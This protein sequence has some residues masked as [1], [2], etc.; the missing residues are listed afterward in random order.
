M[1][2]DERRWEILPGGL[3][4]KPGRLEQHRSYLFAD[5]WGLGLSEGAY[6]LKSF[7]VFEGKT[8]CSLCHVGISNPKQLLRK[9]PACQQLNACAERRRAKFKSLSHSEPKISFQKREREEEEG[10]GGISGGRE[11]ETETHQIHGQEEEER[12]LNGRALLP[13]PPH[14]HHHQAPGYTGQVTW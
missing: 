13:P 2:R 11:R 9:E 4:E 7:Q 8:D 12:K 14:H 10:G 3:V 1:K 5:E 6:D